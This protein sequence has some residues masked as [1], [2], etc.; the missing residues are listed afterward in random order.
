MGVVGW[1]GWYK[2]ANIR[3]LNLNKTAYI[4]VLEYYEHNGDLRFG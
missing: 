1:G 4:R 2:L 3:S